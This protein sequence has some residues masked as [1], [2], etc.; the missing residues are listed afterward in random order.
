MARAQAELFLPVLATGAKVVAFGEE[1]G[2]RDLWRD[3]V[4]LVRAWL[5]R[6]LKTLVL[7]EHGID[8]QRA[9]DRWLET[10]A[11]PAAYS[12]A[13]EA[14]RTV[15]FLEGTYRL[16]DALARARRAGAPLDVLCFDMAFGKDVQGVSP[17]DL[18]RFAEIQRHYHDDDAFDALRERFMID[19]LERSYDRFDAADRVLLIVGAMHAAKGDHYI[20]REAPPERH[21]PTVTNWLAA[22]E[23]VAAIFHYPVRGSFRWHDDAGALQVGEL[24]PPR[25]ILAAFKAPRRKAMVPTAAL[26]DHPEK[27]LWVAGFDFVYVHPTCR[28]DRPRGIRREG[29]PATRA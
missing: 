10:G 18:A 7:F 15:G 19:A 13:F 14:P 20:T 17:D 25:N 6:G 29:S 22:R 21:I 1:H 8:E 16:L 9:V 4:A 27:P 12:K 2:V 5:K 28:P 11:P 24:K 26:P 3:Q 23:A